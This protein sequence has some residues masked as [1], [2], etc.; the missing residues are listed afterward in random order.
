MVFVRLSDIFAKGI[1]LFAIKKQHVLK[2]KHK[3]VICL[4][5][6]TKSS[7]THERQF[8]KIFQECVFMFGCN[9]M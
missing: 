6:K 7:T 4:N 8:E 9:D 3:L 1:V 5:V 2:Q